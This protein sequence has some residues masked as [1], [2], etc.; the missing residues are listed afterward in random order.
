MV[1]NELHDLGTGLALLL[2]RACGS[3]SSISST[4][5]RL[6]ALGRGL[7]RAAHLL[8]GSFGAAATDLLAGSGRRRRASS[9]SLQWVGLWIRLQVAELRLAVSELVA[10]A[11]A[12][13]CGAV[14]AVAALAVCSRPCP[15]CWRAVSRRV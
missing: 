11:A 15:C 6:A 8:L 9:G 12:V 7:G 1:I 13:V 14:G 10:A 2:P 5:P 4:W 3:L